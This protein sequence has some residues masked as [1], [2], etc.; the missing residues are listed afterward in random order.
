MDKGTIT[1]INDDIT[2]ATTEYIMHG[3]NCRGVMGSGVAKA[4]RAEW[5]SV[6]SLYHQY[7]KDQ[8]E[9]YASLLGTVHIVRVSKNPDIHVVNA[10]TQ[11]NY[12]KNG[13]YASVDAV[14]E[15]LTEVC[16]RLCKNRSISIPKIGCGLGGLSW[17]EE[18]LPIVEEISEK[19]G[20]TFFIYEI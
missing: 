6:Y 8:D 2:H 4:I 20:T 18:I 12:G 11:V 15:C 9:D 13:R 16:R 19:Y 14:K 1:Y 7:V 10:F 17:E 5:P 3:V